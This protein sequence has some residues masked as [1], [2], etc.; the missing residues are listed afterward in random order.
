MSVRRTIPIVVLVPLLALGALRALAG[1]TGAIEG[2]VVD[3]ATG[4]PMEGA[5]ITLV[6]TAT[7]TVK[8][9]LVTDKKGHFYKA[10]LYSGAYQLTAEMAGYAP[11]ASTI[12]VKIDDTKKLE[13]RL[14]PAGAAAGQG[15]ASSGPLR[16]TIELIAAG[17]YEEAAA[18]AEAAVT[19]APADPIPYYYRALA[20]ER[21]GQ[22]DAALEDY[23]KAIALK[24][25]FVLPLDRVGMILAR[26]GDFEGAA[27]SYRLAI[28]R[29]DQDPATFYNYG[30][31]L[32]NAGQRDLA[33]AAFE[34]LLAV[35]PLY[36]DGLYQLG[37]IE[38]GSGNSAAAADLLRKF[39][40]M[41]PRSPNAT[42]ATEI[43]KSL[44]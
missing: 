32:V 40:D 39:V 12:R 4:R 19:Q 44:K 7:G 2:T 41:D 35:D 20:K 37:L 28:E 23:R 29:N 26:K 17:R 30:V 31:S 42:I 16:K 10:G 8:F 9:D 24:P 6:S 13:I 14:Q 11:Q 5:R 27:E 36:A 25:D 34:K 3:A 1:T 43:L 21:T 15:A 22:T 38:L 18:E 33:K